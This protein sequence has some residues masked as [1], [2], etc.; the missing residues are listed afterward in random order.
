MLRLGPFGSTRLFL[1]LLEGLDPASV[2]RRE[3]DKSGPAGLFAIR[4][5]LVFLLCELTGGG[6][7][8]A[9]AGVAVGGVESV[10]GT[11]RVVAVVG[12]FL[13]SC[14]APSGVSGI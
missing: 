4:P 7:A 3:R 12:G 2:L 9:V 1:I 6:G 14:G 5:G 13:G 11:E 10:G 8:A